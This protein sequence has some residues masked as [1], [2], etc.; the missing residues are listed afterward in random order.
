MKTF[1]L[2]IDGY[3]RECHKSDVPATSGIYF[4]YRCTYDSKNRTVCLKEILYIG[5]AEN[6]KDRV[7]KHDRYSDFQKEL[8]DGEELCYSYAE[9]SKENLDIVE[10]ALVFMQKPRLNDKLKD[11]YN[12]EDVEIDIDGQCSCVKMD[13]YTITNKEENQ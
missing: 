12:H 4:V 11:S 9:V 7:G 3:W 8:K 6:G 1:K 10:N 13:S 2:N 5:Q